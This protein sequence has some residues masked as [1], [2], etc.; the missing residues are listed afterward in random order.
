MGAFY[1]KEWKCSKCDYSEI[2]IKTRRVIEPQKGVY[3]AEIGFENKSGPT[4]ESS[5]ML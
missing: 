5:I 3:K 1:R 4:I 2:M